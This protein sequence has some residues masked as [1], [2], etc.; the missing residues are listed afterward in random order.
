MAN[1]IYLKKSLAW[2]KK[3]RVDFGIKGVVTDHRALG[4]RILGHKYGLREELSICERIQWGG[5]R[6]GG[7][8]TC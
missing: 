7:C 5:S 2:R 4:R 1:T 6:Q 3:E 8:K